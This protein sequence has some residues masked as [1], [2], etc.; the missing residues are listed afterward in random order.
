MQSQTRHAGLDPAS[1]G[2]ARILVCVFLL[3]FVLTVLHSW[4]CGRHG[5]TTLDARSS[6]A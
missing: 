5:I 1:S 2:F 3:R 6:L 4:L